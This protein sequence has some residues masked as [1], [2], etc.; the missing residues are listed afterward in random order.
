ML[1]FHFIHFLPPSRSIFSILFQPIPSWCLIPVI[2]YCV[3]LIRSVF[4]Q[5][6]STKTWKCQKIRFLVIFETFTPVSLF[7]TNNSTL[8]GQT[9]SIFSK[10]TIFPTS[11]VN[12]GIWSRQALY[13]WHHKIG[14]NRIVL[15]NTKYCS[16]LK[17]ILRVKDCENRKKSKVHFL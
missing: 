9:K 16:T 17:S 15:E 3:P 11:S 1:Q 13:L 14:K 6:L 8:L 10:P 12:I 2:K 4:V 7:W 5:N